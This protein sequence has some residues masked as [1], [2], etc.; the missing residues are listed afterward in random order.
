[1]GLAKARLTGNAAAPEE[2]HTD[3]KAAAAIALTLALP[4]PAIADT[5]VIGNKGENSVSFVDL[6]SGR[7]VRRTPTAAMPHEVALSPDGA[8]AAVVAYG[9][10]TI[11]LF[12]VASGRR[13]ERIDM[14]ANSRPH[15]LVWLP[16]GRL[17]TTAEGSST[18]VTILANAPAETPDRIYAVPTGGE[19]SHMLAVHEGSTAYVVNMK[20]GTV[21]VIDLDGQHDRRSF[22]AGTEPEGIALS[23]DGRRIWVADRA[24]AV[25][26]VFDAETLA[27][28]GRVPTGRTPIRV[29]ISPDG[30]R[31]VVSN[32]ASGDLTVIDT[33]AMRAIRTIPVSGTAEA[34]QVTLLFAPGG[35]RIFV[36][37]TGHDRIAE[38]DLADGTV[39]R[40]LPAGD[41]GDGLGLSPVSARANAE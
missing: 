10:N 40:R 6:E 12:D 3:M 21:S 19:Q 26:R 28:V 30:T 2:E 1:M 7:E 16:D 32:Y 38:V 37:E 31:A 29:A 20:S 4:A 41:M 14:G 24:D 9:S 25:V 8:R 35:G 39:L 23:A 36:A 33:A 27:E 18:L 11:D 13:I 34:K 5:L 17:L 15:G 22:A